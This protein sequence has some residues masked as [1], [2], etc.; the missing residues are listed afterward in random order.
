MMNLQ[1]FCNYQAPKIGTKPQNMSQNLIFYKYLEDISPF[2]GAT[3]TSV[4]DL[5]QSLYSLLSPTE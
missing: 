1:K 4:L 2:C 5:P 3:D